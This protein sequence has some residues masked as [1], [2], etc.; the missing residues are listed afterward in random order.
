MCWILK[1]AICY[2]M[3]CLTAM[4]V[5][6]SPAVNIDFNN[7]GR[8][9]EN[10]RQITVPKRQKGFLTRVLSEAAASPKKVE[11]IHA[12][13]DIMHD[14]TVAFAFQVPLSDTFRLA[15]ENGN[16]DVCEAIL[17]HDLQGFDGQLLLPSDHLQAIMIA[18][19]TNTMPVIDAVLD[20]LPYS[21]ALE[22]IWAA[23]ER[24]AELEMLAVIYLE[25]KEVM[26]EIKRM[27]C[28]Q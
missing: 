19:K 1:Y 17:E 20:T 9:I 21:A 26:I 24:R 25:N 2:L 3:A 8:V 28:S 6:G 12:F 13:F 10:V 27:Q 4:N 22:L 11:F 18:G 16:A 14:R 5:P 15:A 23:K 7:I